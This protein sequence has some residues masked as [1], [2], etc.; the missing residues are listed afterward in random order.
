MASLVAFICLLSFLPSILAAPPIA[1]AG[2]APPGRFNDDDLTDPY[3]LPATSGST[4][5][6]ICSGFMRPTR[7]PFDRIQLFDLAAKAQTEIVKSVIA[8]KGDAAVPQFNLEWYSGHGRL[9][10]VLRVNHGLEREFR[11]SDLSQAIT[12]I[13]EF[14]WRSNFVVVRRISILDAERGEIGTAELIPY[15]SAVGNATTPAENS[16][17]A[18]ENV[19]TA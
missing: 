6:L 10:M 3:H 12:A 17:P 9:G 7:T 8:A 4:I 15:W 2:I 18:V 19:S 16:M 11:W 13:V 1:A 5:S 14:G